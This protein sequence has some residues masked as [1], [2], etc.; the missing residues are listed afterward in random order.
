MKDY[1]HQGL[2][3][4]A[5]MAISIDILHRLAVEVGGLAAIAV[6]EED[7]RKPLLLLKKAVCVPL[8][9]VLLRSLLPCSEYTSMY[10]IPYFPK[11][12]QYRIMH[13]DI[14]HK[15]CIVSKK[16]REYE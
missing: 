3:L 4:I 5:G 12:C 16:S 6:L 8:F 7:M 9:R 14:V 10:S 1:R 13:K 15:L 11:C 2:A